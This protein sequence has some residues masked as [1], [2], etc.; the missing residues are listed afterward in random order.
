MD[1]IIRTK[2]E[3][4]KINRD[5][6][7]I[8][9]HVPALVFFKDRD[10]RFTRVNKAFADFMGVQKKE[11][12][13]KSAF[14]FYT[15]KQAESL[16]NDD[17]EVIATGIPKKIIVELLWGK[18]KTGLLQMEKVPHTDTRG[19]IIGIICFASD[20]SEKK[21]LETVL[22][23]SETRFRRLFETAQDGILILSADTGRINEA[24]QFLVDMLGYTHEELLKK[25]LWEIGLFADITKS[26]NAFKMTQKNG[27]VTYEDMPLQTKEGSLIDVEFVSNLYKVNHN[28]VIQCNI[29]NITHRKNLVVIDENRRLLAEEKEKLDFMAEANHELR[30]PLAIIKGSIDILLRESKGKSDRY[31]DEVLRDINEEVTHLTN[32]L[33]ELALL[34]TSDTGVRNKVVSEKIDFEL[35]VND[36]VKRCDI[37]AKK[38]N[39]TIQKKIPTSVIMGDRR[40]LEKLLLNLIKN[41]LSYGRE[42]GW[43]LIEVADNEDA[44]IISVSDNGIGIAQDDLPKV[45]SRFYRV[46]KSHFSDER[47]TGLG[48]AISK[49]VV[50]AHGGTIVVTSTGLTKGSTFTV[51]LPK[52]RMNEDEK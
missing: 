3:N 13:G 25:K 12:E 18:N 51:T 43:V 46:D 32:I 47:H 52:N 50:E 16:W 28:N 39:I 1:D 45:F 19:N 37:I 35:L 11:L 9:D 15:K 20:I 41:A 2:E 49:R 40:Y 10:N 33:S 26:K 34:A 23:D 36:I 24:N 5:Q 14:D 44:V 21:H 42:G 31:A 30:T 27:Y 7:V 4:E 38:K 22:D 48:L 17:R 6:D 8:L 29:R